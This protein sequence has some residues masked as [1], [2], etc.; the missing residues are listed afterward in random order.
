MSDPSTPSTCSECGAELDDSYDVEVY[1]VEN[2][3]QSGY[4]NPVVRWVLDVLRGGN[5][6]R[7]LHYPTCADCEPPETPVPLSEDQHRNHLLGS[8]LWAVLLGLVTVSPSPTAAS[9]DVVLTAV[10]AIA[11]GAVAFGELVQ[12]ARIREREKPDRKRRWDVEP[13]LTGGDSDSATEA[14]EAYLAGEI[15][16]AELEERLDDELAEDERDRE[17]ERV[18]ER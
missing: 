14:R 8:G 13:V 5:G 7:E 2:P 11:L 4:R 18:M 17:P 15:T 16:E 10:A 9:S 1:H 3:A 6:V 12:I